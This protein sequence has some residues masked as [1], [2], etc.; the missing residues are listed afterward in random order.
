M[1]Y[2]SEKQ[3]GVILNLIQTESNNTVS[4]LLFGFI[5]QKLSVRGKGTEGG[6][7]IYSGFELLF[8]LTV[9]VRQLV[10]CLNRSLYTIQQITNCL[11]NTYLLWPL[12]LKKIG[13]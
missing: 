13:G 10:T 7:T 11:F 5:F 8:N 2:M 9:V 4:Y 3:L 1:G 6:E 12:T